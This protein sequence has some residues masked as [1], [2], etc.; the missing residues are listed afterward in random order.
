MWRAASYAR[1]ASAVL[2]DLLT[3]KCSAGYGGRK[4]Q[5]MT[6]D[7]IIPADDAPRLALRPAE[8]AKA[9]GIGR[10]LLWS[11]TA[12]GQLPHTRLG[13]CVVYPIDGLRAW[14]DRETEGGER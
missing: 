14:L 11:M 3:T 1:C 8:A 12:S 2:C 7:P 13:R 10:R 5:A 6:A 9:L 4:G